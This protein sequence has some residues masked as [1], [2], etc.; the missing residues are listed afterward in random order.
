[1][2][3]RFAPAVHP[4]PRKEKEPMRSNTGE[5]EREERERERREREREGERERNPILLKRVPAGPSPTPLCGLVKTERGPP[6]RALPE[7][8]QDDHLTRFFQCRSPGQSG[9][10]AV[11]A[12][13]LSGPSEF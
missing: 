1:M 11:I 6:A 3:V 9:S 7:K 4:S 12:T 13:S 5:R 8:E 10:G 2:H